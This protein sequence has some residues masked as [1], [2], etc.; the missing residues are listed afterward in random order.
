MEKVGM[1]GSYK[2]KGQWGSLHLL[3]GNAM[4][5]KETNTSTEMNEKF[6]ST[7]ED[8]LRNTS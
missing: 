5:D 6:Y 4:V 8:E 1:F 2:Q 7:T 3:P